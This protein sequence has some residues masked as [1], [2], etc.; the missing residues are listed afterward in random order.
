MFK[1]SVKERQSSGDQY[2]MKRERS[3]ATPKDMAQKILD[4]VPEYC[5]FYFFNAADRYCG[6]YANSLL[7]FS[8]ILKKIDKESLI[9]HFKRGDFEKWIKTTIGDSY[10]AN[11]IS[12]ISEYSNEE[13]LLTKI[14]QIIEKRVIK[15]KQLLAKEEPYIE[16]DDDLE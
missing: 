15:L 10:L 8:S 11:E 9:F 7:V 12:K 13:E 5:A 3:E 16:H 1:I 2:N 6:I 4:E 14:C